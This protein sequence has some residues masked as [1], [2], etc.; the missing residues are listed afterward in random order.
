MSKRRLVS[1]HQC[2]CLHS[3]F[4]EP[5]LLGRERARQLADSC[6]SWHKGL[7][8]EVVSVLGSKRGMSRK[9]AERLCAAGHAHF[10]G[11]GTLLIT[12]LS[13]VDEG[14]RGHRALS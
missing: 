14:R 12:M 9:G 7:T 10:V 11:P 6:K 4:Y 13:G 3:C 2:A 8:T 5:S 1:C